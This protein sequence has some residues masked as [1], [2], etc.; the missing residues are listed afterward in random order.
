[1]QNLVNTQIKETPL[2]LIQMQ[3]IAKCLFTLK[4]WVVAFGKPVYYLR[5]P[6]AVR[7]ILSEKNIAD[8]WDI[9]THGYRC[10][11]FLSKDKIGK[12]KNESQIKLSPAAVERIHQ[13]DFSIRGVQR[14]LA[15]DLGIHECHISRVR[16]G[17]RRPEKVVSKVL[18]EEL[19]KELFIHRAEVEEF[20]KQVLTANKFFDNYGTDYE[21]KSLRDV[22]DMCASRLKANRKTN[23]VLPAGWHSIRVGETW[24]I[25]YSIT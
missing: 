13:T 24:L 12:I 15:K 6:D 11:V 10:Y 5:S 3:R 20:F 2:T 21:I 14:K 7:I 18:S 4:D 19:K 17:I 8:E 1:M 16:R 22:Y 25:Y 23:C 9:Y